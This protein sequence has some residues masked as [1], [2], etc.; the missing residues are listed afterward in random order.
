MNKKQKKII[1]DGRKNLKNTFIDLIFSL[2][3]QRYLN[4]TEGILLKYF[5]FKNKKNDFFNEPLITIFTPTFNRASILKNRAI[6]AVL[7]QSYKNFEYIIVGDGCTDNTEEIVKKIKD[8]R[9]KFFN[10]KRKI[11]Y[12]K[13]VENLWFV[14]PVRAMNFALKQAKGKW[15]ARIDDDIIWHRDHLKRSLEYCKKNNLEF[16]TSA[17]EAIKFKKKFKPKPYKINN[18]TMG[19]AN[20]FF[21]ISYLK[22]F[23]FN[24]HCWKKS[25]NRVNDVDFFDRI[26]KV[27]TRIG[28]SKKINNYVLPRPNESTW[29][30]DQVILKKKEYMKKYFAQ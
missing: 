21:Y 15:L 25:M 5:R 24:I 19:G 10:I 28:F 2:F 9:I 6:K 20:S 14:G 27:G 30:L 8:K 7:K 1:S 3:Y 11:L 4:I 18:Y 22:F 12:K 23:K 16:M 26:S 17:T 13:N 29:G